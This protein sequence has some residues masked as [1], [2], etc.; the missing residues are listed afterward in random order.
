[1]Q[2]TQTRARA[3]RISAQRGNTIEQLAKQQTQQTRH[4]IRSTRERRRRTL[5]GNTSTTSGPLVQLMELDGVSVALQAPAAIMQYCA[6]KC[7][8]YQQLLQET[9]A[10]HG[11]DRPWSMILY[12]DGASPADT[13]SKNDQRKF[14]AVYWSIEEFGQAALGTEEVANAARDTQ[15]TRRGL[16]MS[17]LL[18][19][20]V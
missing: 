17:G 12:A 6:E 15:T 1:M 4:Q 2:L 16:R 19:H 18:K 11:V 8:G 5:C 14:W 9:A 20:Q 10:R 13:L 3:R 7:H